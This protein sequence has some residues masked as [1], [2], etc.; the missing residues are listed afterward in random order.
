MYAYLLGAFAALGLHS[1]FASECVTW[2]NPELGKYQDL[3]QCVTFK[4]GLYQLYR[5]YESDPILGGT[6][7]CLMAT[8]TDSVVDGSLPIHYTFSGGDLNAT[9]TLKSTSGY[10]VKNA[11]DI[12]PDGEDEAGEIQTV[13]RGCQ[14]CVVFKNSYMS[15]SAYSLWVQEDY[16]DQDHTCCDFVYELVTGSSTKYEIYDETCRS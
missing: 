1:V 12:L 7:K 2:D 10:D 6:A 16:L 11:L 5:N 9:V 4:G 8:E 3:E 14:V 15:E 13:F